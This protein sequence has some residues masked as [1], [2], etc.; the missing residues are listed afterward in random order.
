MIRRWLFGARR[1]QSHI[2][3]RERLR[4]FCRLKI[5][6]LEDR[7]L[8]A[9][10]DNVPGDD[11][12]QLIVDP[13][14]AP[15][16][17]IVQ[18]KSDT[19]FTSSLS[20][21]SYGSSL[22][23][24]WDLV[25]DMREVQLNAGVNVQ[26]ALAAYSNDSNVVHA[27]PDYH[28]KLTDFNVPP[29]DEHYN[30]QWDLRNTGQQGGN[31]GSDIHMEDAWNAIQGQSLAPVVVAVIDTGVD[32]THPD[33]AP[34]MWT[35]PGEIP[36]NGIDDD[37]DGY[38]D[39]VYGYNFVNNNGDPM[40]DYFHGTHVAGTIAAVADNGIGI[41][42]IAP[43]VQIMALKFLDDT[44]SGV[45]SDAIRALNYAVAHGAQISNNSWGGLP[46]SAAFQT[47]LSNAAAKGHIFVAAAGNNGSND[48]SQGFYPASY[49]NSNVVSVAATDAG[50]SLA[51]F[52]NF[53]KKSVDIGAPGVSIL[54]TLP[55]IGTPA[56]DYEGLIPG[57]GVLDGT[58]MAAPHVSGVMALVWGM[59][60]DWSMQ[61][62]IA[63]VL[64]TADPVPSLASM[65]KTGGRLDAAAALGATP[66]DTI[67]PTFI[68]G[69]PGGVAAAPVDHVRIKFSEPI[70]PATFDP[71]DIV[72]FDGPDGAVFAFSVTPV[73]GDNTTFDID[74]D[75]QS[76]PGDYT[77]V[78]GPHMTDMAGNEVDEN[79]DRVSDDLDNFQVSFSILGSGSTVG[80]YPSTDVPKS[81]T[82]R[83]VFTSTLAID[84]DLPIADVNVALDLTYP[85][86]GNLNIWLVSPMGTTVYLSQRR[87]GSTTGSQDFTGTVFDDEADQT[88]AE[89]TAPFT[90]A[91]RP[92]QLLS[93]FIGENA[94]GTWQLN[95]QNASNTT[96]QGTLTGWSLDITP[97]GTSSG[98][99]GDDGGGDDGG[100]GGSQNDPPQPQDDYYTVYTGDSLTVSTA[101]MLSNDTDPNGD[102]LAVYSVGNPIGGDVV[103]DGHTVTFT[104]T[105]DSLAPA[106]FQYSAFDGYT[107]ATAT[108]HIAF[109]DF[110]DYHNYSNPPDVDA[111]GVIS[112][113]DIIT[114]I[115]FINSH[116]GST[117]V[118]K[119]HPSAAPKGFID[120]VADN[121]I[122][123][124][125]VVAV[126][127][128]I[129]AHPHATS[130][131]ASDATGAAAAAPETTLNSAAVDAY[132][133]STTLDSGL[134]AKKK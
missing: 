86:D 98:G 58:S 43:N 54:S 9:L 60:P 53:G 61:E 22:G 12:A 130:V 17:L 106:S 8:L 71:S 72:S 33:L 63:D 64:N 91:F 68:L 55:M 62:V 80:Q 93:S 133:L 100:G 94:F 1:G 78:V 25:P 79:G 120:V 97:D 109:Q 23:E 49:T 13:A 29:N 27:E 24:S 132:L 69:D 104:P 103:L 70:D 34:V 102:P 128:Y 75:P 40:D 35:N 47:A 14:Q 117:N 96:R 101:D 118:G 16:S 108:V 39:D 57:Y 30:D 41:A 76:T 51:Y 32:Y 73:N 114:I 56:M 65:I 11:N 85:R 107:I 87:G 59:H 111:D 110:Y 2:A 88:I 112:A 44:G 52:S 66:T 7:R 126:I 37:D 10:A 83:S 122:A 18:F 6:S 131:S 92:D 48:D 121:T 90:G 95:I 28:V 134:S 4:R 129:N 31:V 42:G 21:Y 45:E 15:T 115:N 113:T 81:I 99:G 46:F 19:D 84:Q 116:P 26:A 77:L 105:L 82:N 38:V 50:D 74:F 89:G 20:A 67:A 3:R 5:E 127:N 124:N 125:D 123:A 36:D 119:I